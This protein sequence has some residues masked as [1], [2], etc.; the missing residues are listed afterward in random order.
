MIHGHGDEQ[1]NDIRA[2]FSSNVWYAAKHEA[3]FA[4]LASHMHCISNYPDVDALSLRQKIAAKEEIAIDNIIACNGSVEGIYLVAQ[5]FAG[6]KTLIVAPTFAEYADAAKMHQHTINYCKA[7]DLENELTAQNYDT[8][9]ICNP[10]NPDGHCFEKEKLASLMRKHSGC[11]FIIDQAYK[12]F[13]NKPYFEAKE[14]QNFGNIILLESL[15]KHYAIPGLRLGYIMANG[16]LSAKIREK[17]IPWSVN[18]LAIEAGKFLLDYPQNINLKQWL[19][20]SEGLQNAIAQMP[21]FVVEKSETPF[22]LF[23]I[24]KGKAADLKSFLLQNK[25]LVRNATNFECL[26]GEW[27]RVCALSNEKNDLLLEKLQQWT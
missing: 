19:H 10:N 13:C 2:N 25:I 14:L 3:L 6:A 9:W 17:Q 24:T 21:N 4:H 15:T 27:I 1:V 23:K 8:V 16:T 22:F 18:S 20:Q 11:I 12:E 26:E 7:I 5:S